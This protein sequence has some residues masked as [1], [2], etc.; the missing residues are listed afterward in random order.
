MKGKE[1]IKK[2]LDLG[3]DREILIQRDY[4]APTC[5]DNFLAFLS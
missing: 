3:V 2:I 1:L 4:N 5:Q